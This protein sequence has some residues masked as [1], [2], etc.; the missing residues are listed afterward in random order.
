MVWGTPGTNG[1]HA[2]YQLIH[3]GT[4]LIP[5]DFIGFLEPNHEVGPHHD[6]LM[7]NFFAQT[8]A[9]AFGKTAAEVVAEGVPAGPGPAPDLP[10]QPPD[11]HPPGPQADPRILGELVATYE[12]KV[13]TQ[14]VI[15]GID[16][17][18]QWGVELGK[19]LAHRLAPLLT[20]PDSPDT[21]SLDSSTAELVRRFREVRAGR[22]E[23]LHRSTSE[24][25]GDRTFGEGAP[26]ARRRATREA[27]YGWPMR[28]CSGWLGIR[29]R[30]VP[31][32]LSPRRLSSSRCCDDSASRL[33]VPRSVSSSRTRRWSSSSRD[34]STSPAASARSISPTALWCRRRR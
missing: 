31:G 27:G 20:S 21:S 6:L 16:S 4:R 19:A 2:Y 22:F 8:E 17:F 14:G 18:D 34:R 23:A 32:N 7:A 25:R 13:L 1:Q 3:Q 24:S 28:P 26:S 10:R 29:P 9:L 15:W 11:Q 30:H 5:A 12:H 33:F